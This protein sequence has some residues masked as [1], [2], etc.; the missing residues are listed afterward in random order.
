[1]LAE[2]SNSTATAFS[3][4]NRRSFTSAGCHSTNSTSASIAICRLPKRPCCHQLRLA[5][6]HTSAPT[7]SALHSSTRA[8][9]SQVGQPL[10]STNSLSRKACSGYL[11]RNS[12]MPPSRDFGDMHYSSSTLSPLAQFLCE[13]LCI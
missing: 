11:K 10:A 7:T 9:N 2:V 13:A 6:F 4:G 5:R 1:M 12:I 8:S 3:P